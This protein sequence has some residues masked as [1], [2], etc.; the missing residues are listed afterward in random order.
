M[1]ATTGQ[2]TAPSVTMR[3]ALQYRVEGDQ[4]FLSHQDELRVIH[5]ALVRA[6]WPLAFSQG[7]NPQPKLAI[8][9][10]RPLGIASECQLALVGLR[11]DDANW[12]ADIDALRESFPAG[13]TLA[14][15]RGPLAKGTPLPQRVHYRIELPPDGT[16]DLP[17]RIADAL[18]Q[19]TLPIERGFGPGKPRRKVDVR[20][21]LAAINLDG[22]TL[23][24]AVQFIDS[25]AARPAEVLDVLGVDSTNTR[26]L[27]RLTAV[28][29]D[30]LPA[31]SNELQ[32]DMEGMN[33][34]HKQENNP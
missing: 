34:G 4:R 30:Q 12:Q 32:R 1:L 7:F 31:L 33:L 19:D 11:P 21:H 20:P 29:W 14:E 6:R 8:A 23:Q 22:I 5:R 15:V 26:H 25:R 16:R 2:P 18:A 3:F 13:F 17:Q 28:D 9:L 10:P 27:I 24:F